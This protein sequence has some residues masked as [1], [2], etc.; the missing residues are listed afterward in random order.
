M[1]LLSASGQLSE[2]GNRTISD[3]SHVKLNRAVQSLDRGPAPTLRSHRKWAWRQLPCAV[4][5]VLQ[6]VP[7]IA[8]NGQIVSFL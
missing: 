3:I 8:N 2:A 6:N 1:Y 5:S 4:S 7:G